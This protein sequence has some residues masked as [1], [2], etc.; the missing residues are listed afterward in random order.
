MNVPPGLVARIH[1]SNIGHFSGDEPMVS[2][3]SFTKIGHVNLAQAT[4][5]Q[6]HVIVMDRRG[7]PGPGIPIVVVSGTS[8]N[9]AEGTT[10]GDGVFIAD[11]P[12]GMQSAEI[13]ATLPEGEVHEPVML[14]PLGATV[15]TIRSIRK[16]SGPFLTIFEGLMGF[17]G[18]GTAVL[19]FILDEDILKMVGEGA[20]F[21]AVFARVGRET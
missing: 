6:L 10:D 2:F 16:I 12:T 15:A 11:I 4:G 8:G 17:G 13:V 14:A 3:P 9:I 7:Q 21:A 5:A 20:F 18:L 19:G 1:R